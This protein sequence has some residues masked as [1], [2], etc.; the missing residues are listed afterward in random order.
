[1]LPQTWTDVGLVLA[2]GVTAYVL[3]VAV[4]RLSGKRTLASLNAFDM[5]V[6]V[7]LGS[8]LATTLV[9]R[10]VSLVEGVV[11]VALLVSL[12]AVVAFSSVRISRFRRL[13]KAEP[14][15]LLLDGA[16]LDDRLRRERIAA[17]EVRQAVRAAGYGSLALVHAVVMETDGTVSVIP[18]S[19][20][21]DGSALADVD[22][23]VSGEV[24]PGGATR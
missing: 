15:L 19:Q 13:V 9:S 22:R 20:S 21:G 17:E 6:T 24:S 11:A 7:A 3:V 14:T 5:V 12:Q 16:L 10:S 2:V 8:T 4:L 23:P 1:M 18:R